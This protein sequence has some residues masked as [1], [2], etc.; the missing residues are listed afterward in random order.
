MPLAAF[1]TLSELRAC[2]KKRAGEGG[3]A[4]K[5][6]GEEETYDF[7]PFFRPFFYLVLLWLLC[8]SPPPILRPPLVART[9]IFATAATAVVAAGAAGITMSSNRLQIFVRR[10]NYA[11]VPLNSNLHEASVIRILCRA[12]ERSDAEYLVAMLQ[13]VVTALREGHGVNKASSDDMLEVLVS[14]FSSHVVNKSLA[15]S[16]AS[17]HKSTRAGGE[18]DFA[19]CTIL[20][21][22]HTL[23][24]LQEANAD[25]GDRAGD[26]NACPFLTST[27]SLPSPPQLCHIVCSMA[28]VHQRAVSD[29]GAE[30][31]CEP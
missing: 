3:R 31:D 27:Q 21:A 17:I 23:E 2:Q 8:P 7:R 16:I 5:K 22:L 14:I 25:P 10:K 19:C 13:C 6:G 4:G 11:I 28:R 26:R 1:L 29:G 30:P 9:A 20:Q 12:C 24:L 18:E 15:L